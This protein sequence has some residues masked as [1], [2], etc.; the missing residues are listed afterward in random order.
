M[1]LSLYAGLGI[2]AGF[3]AL[4]DLLF[5][6]FGIFGRDYKLQKVE[7]V[8]VPN[9]A[10]WF[11]WAAIGI[12]TA[13]SYKASGATDTVW[14]PVAYAV[15]F[16]VIALLSIK[17]GEGGFNLTDGLCLMGSILAGLGW[18]YFRAPEVAL[19]ASLL[20]EALASIPTILKSWREPWKENK[21]AWSLAVFASVLNVFALDWNEAGFWVILLPLYILT[22]NA[23]ITIP[24]Y[25]GVRR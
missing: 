25:L 7:N 1:S 2:A 10:T 18:W 9:R 13:M 8:T 12:I 17:Y 19:A 21:L 15:G 11:I 24:L 3:V 23:L 5:Y 16:S 22:L 20:I 6:I 4:A 14:F